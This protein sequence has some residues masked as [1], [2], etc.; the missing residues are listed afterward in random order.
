MVLKVFYIREFHL[1]GFVVDSG[2]SFPD[3]PNRD[4]FSVFLLARDCEQEVRDQSCKDLDHESMRT[5]G[6]QVV[7]PQMAFPPRK[8]VLDIPPELIDQ[9]HLLGGQIMAVGGHPI[10]VPV[11]AIANKPNRVF[12]LA[13]P[14]RPQ[15][16]DGIGKHDRVRGDRVARDLDRRGVALDA[17]DKVFLFAL[18]PIKRLMAWIP[19]R[20]SGGVPSADHAASWR[21]RSPPR[22]SV[23]MSA[24]FP[25]SM[26]LAPKSGWPEEMWTSS[27]I[28]RVVLPMPVGAQS[29]PIA[30]AG[31]SLSTM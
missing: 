24:T 15:Q 28:T 23:T 16:D 10:G 9:G 25:G 17:A 19:A 12:R 7:H 2:A 30:F 18:Q 26:M 21:A 20:W 4:C 29:A 31:I 11:G 27:R 3:S 22:P 6:N 5:S 13:P 1:T 14:R 8:K